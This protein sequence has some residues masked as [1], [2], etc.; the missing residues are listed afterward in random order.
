MIS[1][2]EPK[3]VDNIL[4]ELGLRDLKITTELKWEKDKDGE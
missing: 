4:E 1:G 2:V 3:Y